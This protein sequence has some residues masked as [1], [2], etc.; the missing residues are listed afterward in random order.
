MS[1]CSFCTRKFFFQELKNVFHAGH[2]Y[3][4][5]IPTINIIT[6]DYWRR[7]ARLALIRHC[8]RIQNNNKT[9][10]SFYLSVPF[11]LESQSDYKVLELT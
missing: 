9:R 2:N 6:I 7:S 10:K 1:T 8:A 11:D 4:R 3:I 5:N